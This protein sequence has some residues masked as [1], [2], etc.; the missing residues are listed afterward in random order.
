MAN[1]QLDSCH[2]LNTMSRVGKY[3][4]Y[5]KLVDLMVYGKIKVRLSPSLARRILS[6]EAA[7]NDLW[8]GRLALTKSLDAYMANLADKSYGA[9]VKP[10][11]QGLNLKMGRE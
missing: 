11:D 4:S 10:I 8:L 3:V 6:L 5:D 9:P 2:F 7:H 1:F